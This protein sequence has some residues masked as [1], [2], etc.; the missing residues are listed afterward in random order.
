M[1][2]PLGLVMMV[3]ESAELTL[4]VTCTS[5]SGNDLVHDLGKQQRAKAPSTVLIMST[6]PLTSPTTSPSKAPCGAQQKAKSAEASPALVNNA[7]SIIR[8]M[9]VFFITMEDNS[10]SFLATAKHRMNL[11]NAP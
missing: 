6:L 11:F 3:V 5:T 2:N 1:I 7:S 9:E 4:A 10:E 8:K